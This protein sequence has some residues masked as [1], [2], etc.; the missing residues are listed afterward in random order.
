MM[1][2]PE[3][4]ES[5]RFTVD[6][7]L[8]RELGALLVGR[9]ST[10]LVELIKNTY[11]ADASKVT[12][13]GQGL[14]D[15]SG[16][17]TVEDDGVGMTPKEFEAGFLRIASRSKEQGDRRS[18]RYGRRFTGAKGVGRL[19]AHKLAARLT[20]TSTPD[21]GARA[22]EQGVGVDATID[23]DIVEQYETLDEA[24]SGIALATRTLA[25]EPPGTTITLDR[26]RR[27]WTEKALA[28]FL[29]ELEAF[30]PP[31][32]LVE[33]LAE[34]IAAGPF[35]FTTPHV[36]STRPVASAR[37]RP[38]DPGFEIVALGDFATGEDY[39]DRVSARSNWVIELKAR[40]DGV[41][42]IVAPTARGPVSGATEPRRFNWQHP[43]PKGGPFFDA[44]LLV[45]EGVIG[46]AKDPVADFTRRVAGV[47][48]YMEGF[49]VLPYGGPGDDWLDLDR[50]YA[51]RTRELEIPAELGA[52]D[53]GESEYFKI[54][55]NQGYYGAV[56]LTSDQAAG[57]EMVVSREGFIPNDSFWTMR[58]IVR[59]AID[60]STR[61]RAAASS[62]AAERKS[63]D[64]GSG[65]R[66]DPDEPGASTSA[67]ERGSHGERVASQLN[68]AR[69]ALVRLRDPASDSPPEILDDLDAAIAAASD[70]IDALLS[71]QSTLR[72]LASVGQQLAEF[73]HETNGMLALARQ[74]TSLLR[75]PAGQPSPAAIRAATDSAEQLVR[76]I[77]RQASYL[78]EVLSPDS[79]R[80]RSRRQLSR[81]VHAAAQLVA[82][83][84][85]NRGITVT[86]DVPNTL[87]TLP[88]FGA[89][90]TTVFTNLLT[91]AV[92]GAGSPG[93][94]RIVGSAQGATTNVTI[95]NTGVAV[96]LATSEQWFRPFESTTSEIDP[97]LGQGMGLGLTIVRA[98]LDD[99]GG[100]VAFV[101]P[102]PGFATAVEVR[103]PRQKR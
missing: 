25:G 35:L 78:V 79:R 71:T 55:S 59:S 4:P 90:L 89:E 30:R 65:R 19:S 100:S 83:R 75:P 28:T 2:A 11:D 44:R 20:V 12:I 41:T 8:F 82:S 33:P 103:I 7:H 57:L 74:V 81:S 49:R 91:N 101:E 13:T 62:Q 17:I 6:T 94:I 39:W 93:E 34:G 92:K 68:Q 42:A 96:D 1:S 84:T 40:R 86:L 32:P 53:P 18:A 43:D 14:A 87:E 95:E 58:S 27:R 29:A 38:P 99:Y 51:R 60:L 80:R 52:G 24:S 3:S 70:G 67:P 88:M 97:V 45:R 26:L 10:A 50:D 47:R 76:L 72:V 63:G 16:S 36:L 69:D 102:S 48:V 9:D 61:V 15:G 37:K 77:D 64:Q 85:E 22:L 73:V 56:F 23:W 98:T 66:N 54:L 21:L 31:P 46:P 5:P